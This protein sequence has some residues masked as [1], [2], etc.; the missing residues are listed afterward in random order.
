MPTVFPAISID[1]MDGFE[2]PYPGLSGAVEQLVLLEQLPLASHD[3]GNRLFRYFLNAIVRDIHDLD[4]FTRGCFQI[5]IVIANTMANDELAALQA[6]D[7]LG[8]DL[9]HVDHED[10]GVRAHLN[11]LI[12]TRGFQL[13]SGK[14]HTHLLAL[15]RFPEKIGFYVIRDDCFEVCHI[16]LS[17]MGLA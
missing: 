7:Y 2:L 4:A 17:F 16:T 10:I 12:H 5:H 8:I 1:G 11:Q 6:L 13:V 9:S 15:L 3:Q 14:I